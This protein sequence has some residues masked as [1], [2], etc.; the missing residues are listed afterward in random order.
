M[1]SYEPIGALLR[2]LEVLRA[3]NEGGAQT[4][5]D[6]Y[7][8]TGISKPTLV[9]IIETLHHAG[10]VDTGNVE[11]RYSVT[12]RVLSLAN[13]YEEQRWIM[14]VAGPL[15]DAFRATAGWPVEL[16]VFDTDAMVILNTS[17]Q[18]GY[19]SVNRKPGSR[20]PLLKTALGRA[21]VGA[22]TLEE[23]RSLIARL[24]LR[25]EEEFESARSPRTLER[26]LDVVRERGYSTADRET[27]SNGRALA[28]AIIVDGK[29]RASV[30]LVAHSSAMSM[31]ELEDKWAP[32]IV[33]LGKRIAAALK[34]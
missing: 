9:R 23:R 13:G 17:R 5:G 10:Y 34:R 22:L 21:Y 19:L 2:G 8:V 29:P 27:L 28:V 7:S 26:L 32:Q 14:E 1:A 30:N 12:P 3:L 16:G 25:T 15:L 11:R 18:S 24:A 6:L 4:I 33:E 20:V 31:A